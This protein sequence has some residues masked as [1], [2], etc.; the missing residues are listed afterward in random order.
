MLKQIVLT[1]VFSSAILTGCMNNESKPMMDDGMMK[2]DSMKGDMMK[3]DSM[4][5]DMMDDGIMKDSM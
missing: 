2:H 4:K 1:V 5:G 3:K